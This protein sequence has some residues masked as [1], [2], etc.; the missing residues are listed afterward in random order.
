MAGPLGALCRVHDVGQFPVV[1]P[2]SES[3]SLGK[4]QILS[5]SFRRR[6][7]G[8]TVPLQAMR[9]ALEVVCLA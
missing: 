5:A 7:R 2:P 6:L 8:C 1:L 4:P 3:W 9:E